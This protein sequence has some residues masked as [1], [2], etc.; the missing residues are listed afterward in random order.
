PLRGAVSVALPGEALD[1]PVGLEDANVRE[2]VEDRAA[3]SPALDESGTP[4]HGEVL[5]HVRHLAPDRRRQL[6]HGE[7]AG[8]QRFEHAQTLGVRQGSPDCRIALAVEIARDG[9]RCVEHRGQSCQ[10][11]R[12]HASTFV[13]E[14]RVN[15]SAILGAWTPPTGSSASPPSKPLASE[16]ATRYSGRHTQPPPPP[17]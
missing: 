2:T 3:L 11:L 5:A 8:R 6:A 7:L 4:Q 13:Q 1:E 14:W 12:K 10:C 16:S 17:D 9:D 15:A